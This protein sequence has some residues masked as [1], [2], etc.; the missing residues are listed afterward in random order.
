MVGSRRRGTGAISAGAV[1]IV[2]RIVYALGY[3]A[4]AGKRAPGFLIQSLATAVLLF[5]SLGRIVYL[6]ATAH[7]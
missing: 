6:I 5:G 3:Y 1:W 2:G 4:E 7:G